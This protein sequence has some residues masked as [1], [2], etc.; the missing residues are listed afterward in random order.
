M[1]FTM[2]VIINSTS[3]FCGG[4]GGVFFVSVLLVCV[5]LDVVGP[6]IVQERET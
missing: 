2:V 5:H 1:G 3:F 4:S 6:C